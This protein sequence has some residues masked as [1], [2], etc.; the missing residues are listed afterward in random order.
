MHK[1]SF[2]LF[3]TAHATAL[4]EEM[5]SLLGQPLGKLYN[6]RFSD[7]EVFSKFEETIR[8]E[9]VVLIAQI[10]MPYENLFSLFTAADAARRA[11]ASEI[12][13]VIPY[14]PHSRQE[15]RDGLRTAVTSRL[16]ADFIEH[17]GVSRLITIDLHSPA[18]EGFYTIPIDHI[19]MS[20]MFLDDIKARFD[21][22]K[23]LLC[24]PDFGGLKRI[25]AYKKSLQTEMAV[26]HKERLKHNQVANMEIIGSPADK[27]VIIIDD[28]IDTGETLCKAASLLMEQGALSVSAYCSHG[29]L[30]ADA[31]DRIQSSPLNELVITNTLPLKLHST[32]IRVL[33]CAPLLTKAL[34]AILQHK[35]L[36]EI[37]KM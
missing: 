10:D 32:K 23:V 36:E 1:G 22:S 27:H 18:I 7:G 35:S 24:S 9:T 6:T 31:Q 28:L 29:V 34:N 4:G 33:S 26:I 11:S 20:P 16:L 19:L 37:N 30:S 3:A 17:S 25:R 15:R 5:S 13:A 12:L 14:L 8:G 2:K 21:L